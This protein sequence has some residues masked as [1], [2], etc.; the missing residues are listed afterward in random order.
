M[1]K[2]QQTSLD[3]IFQQDT[4]SNL[5][6]V[7]SYR[8]IQERYRITSEPKEERE[9]YKT[10]KYVFTMLLEPLTVPPCICALFFLL[11]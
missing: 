7:T 4:M 1:G 8:I 2:T 11:E 3:K 5:L 10:P 6:L 9:R